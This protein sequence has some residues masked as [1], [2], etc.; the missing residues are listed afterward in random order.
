MIKTVVLS[1]KAK[2]SFVRDLKLNGIQYREGLGNMYVVQE[3]PK[4]RMAIRM[5]KERHGARAI[6]VKDGEYQW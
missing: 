6:H 2:H 4:V 5:V 3:C 1:Q